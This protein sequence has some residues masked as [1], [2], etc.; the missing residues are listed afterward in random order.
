VHQCARFSA[1][2]KVEHGKA[3]KWIGRYLLASKD[4]GIVLKP[5]DESFEVYADADFSGNWNRDEASDDPD[6]A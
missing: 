3:V 2:P 4:K 5:K 1:N 6:T